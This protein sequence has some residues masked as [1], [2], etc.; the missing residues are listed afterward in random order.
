MDEKF[1]IYAK[2]LV[3]SYGSVQ[4]LFGV[5]LDVRHGEI[6]GFLGPNGA[7]KTTTI[8][9]ML[10][11]IRPQGGMLSVMGFNP[12][13]DPVAVRARI[14]YL[15]GELNLYNNY[16]GQG[17]LNLLG[18][19]GGQRAD[20]LYI[21][22]L[23]ERLQLD[24]QTPIK[25]LSRGNKQKVGVVQAFMHRS[26][27]IVLDEPTQG[28]DPLM[29]KEVLRIIRELREQ[30]STI[31]FSSHIISE[32]EFLADRVGIIRKG[33][34]V[35]VMEPQ[36]LRDRA[37]R[38]VQVRFQNAIDPQ[39]FQLDGMT[40][41]ESNAAGDRISLQVTGEMDKLIK[42]LANF[43]IRDL[44]IEH[45]SLEEVFLTYYRDENGEA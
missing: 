23:A 1:A 18:S 26:K 32:V 3:K 13:K 36:L 40:V 22:E 30:G 21:R 7:G 31:F 45:P 5:D 43:P 27:L 10:D 17:M 4:A 25:N 37:M 24:L 34:V 35:E 12:Q 28:L 15:P 6:F 19:L 44:E 8:R 9:C 42:T 11:L 20:P 41:L 2:D 29:Q 39:A 14:G 16:T 38:N 33:K